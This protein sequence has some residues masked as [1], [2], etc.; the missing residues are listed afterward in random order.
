MRRITWAVLSLLLLLLQGGLR[1]KIAAGSSGRRFRRSRRHPVIPHCSATISEAFAIKLRFLAPLFPGED[2]LFYCESRR[3]RRNAAE[4]ERKVPFFLCCS[5]KSPL[6]DLE[7]LLFLLPVTSL[8]AHVIWQKG[9][10]WKDEE[11]RRRDSMKSPLRF[12][13]GLC[14]A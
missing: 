6:F 9:T 12:R 8:S 4:V 11:R 1:K 7:I 2:S 13:L 10:L 14:Q 5:P 3:L